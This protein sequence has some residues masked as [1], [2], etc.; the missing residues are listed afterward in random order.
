M[1]MSVTS[2]QKPGDFDC[3]W[4]R[5]DD[6]DIDYLREMAPRILNYYDSAAQKARYGW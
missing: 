6:V 2:Q 3:C 5:D 4:D 1:V